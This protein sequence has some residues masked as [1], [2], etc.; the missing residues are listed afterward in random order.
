MIRVQSGFMSEA[1]SCT[2]TRFNKECDDSASIEAISA[3][4]LEGSAHPCGVVGRE[5]GV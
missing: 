3:V 1:T 4:D 2:V 5:W